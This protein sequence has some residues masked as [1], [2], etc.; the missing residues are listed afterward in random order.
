MSQFWT[1]G[2]F[3]KAHDRVEKMSYRVEQMKVFMDILE[4]D[5]AN[6]KLLLS[7]SLD[8]QAVAAMIQLDIDKKIAI[9]LGIP[10]GYEEKNDEISREAL[11][12]LIR[13]GTEE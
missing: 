12:E 10:D 13:K 1:C 7:G 11:L 8:E 5:K 2:P 3:K 9:L 6:Q 4:E